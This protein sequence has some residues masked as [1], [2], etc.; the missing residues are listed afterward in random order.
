M[1][2]ADKAKLAGSKGIA[3][4]GRQGRFQA[5]IQIPLGLG[6]GGQELCRAAVQLRRT[7]LH[8][9]LSFRTNQTAESQCFRR[10]G[11]RGET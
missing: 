7:G 4:A 9:R 6:D 8:Q 5:A 3:P 11:S 1:E 10:H 2:T